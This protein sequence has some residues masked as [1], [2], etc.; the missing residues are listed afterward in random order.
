MSITFRAL[1]LALMVAAS[2][3]QAGDI[4]ALGDSQL[5][6][7]AGYTTLAQTIT[8][9]FAGLRGSGYSVYAVS[10]AKSGDVLNAQLPAALANPNNTC[11]LLVVGI[12]DLWY[13]LQTP[14]TGASA[15]TYQNNVIRIIQA[16]QAAGKSITVMSNYPFWSSPSLQGFPEYLRM[17]RTAAIGNGVPYLDWYTVKLDGRPDATNNG[18]NWPSSPPGTDSWVYQAYAGDVFHPNEDANN[19][20]AALCSTPGGRDACVCNP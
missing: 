13:N 6:A 10:G 2:P 1:W 8:A 9:K 20:G 14:P 7:R 4:A 15:Q 3:A 19:A 5:V 18:W 11:F 16:V 17:L 12:N